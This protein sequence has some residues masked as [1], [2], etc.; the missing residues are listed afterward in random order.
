MVSPTTKAD[1]SVGLDVHQRRAGL[2]KHRFEFE[3]HGQL[4]ICAH[5][6]PLSV[7]AMRVRNPDCSPARIHG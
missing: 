3:K 7:V 2:P 4:L 5:N 1:H 6:V